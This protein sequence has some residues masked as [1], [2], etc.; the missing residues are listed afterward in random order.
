MNATRWGEV[1]RVC[2]MALAREPQLRA[3]FLDEACAGDAELR[4]EVESLLAGES[5]AG[6]FLEEPALEAAALEL[7]ARSASVGGKGPSDGSPLPAGER[8][9]PY[10]IESLI[11]TGGMGEVYQ[12]RDTRLDRTVAIKVLPPAFAG[13]PQRRGR[14]EREAMAVSGLNHPHICALYDVGEHN[15]STFLVME[16]LDGETLAARLEKGSLPLDQA[17]AIATEIAEALAAAHRQGVVHR[18]LKPGNVML[19]RTGAKLLDFGLAKLTGHGEQP[20]AA[21]L[22]SGSRSKL[23]TEGT[24][25]GTLQY[26]APEQLEGKPADAR[27]DLFAFGTVLYEMLTGRRAFEGTS[28]AS[29]MAAILEREPPPPSVLQ[30]LT[31][32][33]LDRLVRHCLAKDPDTRRQSAADLA[34]DLR[35]VRERSGG[36]ASAAAGERARRRSGLRWA[37]IGAGAL[38]VVATA[39]AL[40]WVLRPVP[41]VPAG[42]GLDL[43]PAEIGPVGRSFTPGT[44]H[45]AF[46][47]S[48]DGRT[49]AFSGIRGGAVHLYRRSIGDAVATPIDGTEEGQQPVVS[50]D[51]RWVAFWAARTIR[52]VPFGGGAVADL[53]S[54]VAQPAGMAWDDAG[55]L[56]F[57]GTDNRIWAIAPDTTTRPVTTLGE[58][59]RAHVLPSVLPGGKDLLFTVR[60]RLWTWGDEQVV[61]QTLATGSRKLLLTDAADARYLPSGHLVFMRR[62]AL[63]AVG[64]DPERLGVRGTPAVV[65]DS[66]AQALTGVSSFDITGAGHFAVSADGT[67][68]WIRSPVV[69]YL[70]K[71]LVTVDRHG[72]IGR[73]PVEPRPYGPSVRL[74]PNG[75]RLVVTTRTSTTSAVWVCDL[76]RGALTP[77]LMDT[78][79][80]WPHWWAKDGGRLLIDRNQHGQGTFVSVFS[81]GSGQPEVLGPSARLWPSSFTPDGRRLVL[82]RDRGNDDED[83]VVTTVGDNLGRLESLVAA[84]EKPSN[85]EISPDGRWLAY[86][87]RRSGRPEVYVRP[88]RGSGGPV[89][90]SVEGGDSPAWNP[91]GGELFFPSTRTKDGT[92]WMMAASVSPVMEPGTPRRLFEFEAETLQFKCNPVRCYDVAPDGQSFYAVHGNVMAFPAPVRHLNYMPNWIDDLKAKVPAR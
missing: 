26:M 19:T 31:P 36:G 14:F 61:A 7:G 70:D 65:M 89:Q 53:A 88:F 3:A 12:A 49:L 24:I 20:A 72:V 4:R 82:V 22:P 64:F 32:P 90:V 79:G 92:F 87:S 37:L 43:R 30:P 76:A 8:L 28:S 29:V 38:V 69:E 11:G 15:G 10:R 80:T 35:W 44:A 50:P 2:R 68:A 5:R 56:F 6:G 41:R 42:L 91:K 78:E 55:S 17:L 48:A 51:G 52:K 62:G 40:T 73:L 45:T 33:T 23:T 21:Q 27:T 75:R 60:R 81:D 13:D 25:V 9:G 84:A 18:D 1:E 57:G 66:V 47:W 85:A 34:D 59:E 83:L 54:D 77:A 16:H 71:A 63:W 67:L 74:S 46:A 58:G 39:V 86:V